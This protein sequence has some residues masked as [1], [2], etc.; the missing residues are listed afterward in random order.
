MPKTAGAARLV[1]TESDCAKA[2]CYVLKGLVHSLEKMTVCKLAPG[3]YR[4]FLD[5]L[6]FG[7]VLP[8]LC[9][10]LGEVVFSCYAT[11]RRSM[12]MSRFLP[13][14]FGM[15][16]RSPRLSYARQMNMRLTK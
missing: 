3:I 16:E 9:Q 1:L 6:K 12:A 5:G 13:H 7:A 15:S 8:S 14:L 11:L 4:R 2:R 10:E